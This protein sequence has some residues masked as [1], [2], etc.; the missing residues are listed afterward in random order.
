VSELDSAL[1]LANSVALGAA[2]LGMTRRPPKKMKGGGEGDDRFAEFFATK[3]ESDAEV[4]SDDFLFDLC[5]FDGDTMAMAEL[6]KNPAVAA[7]LDFVLVTC[8]SV[9]SRL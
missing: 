7:V 5:A 6:G 8:A 4:A 2:R 1:A 3:A 9:E